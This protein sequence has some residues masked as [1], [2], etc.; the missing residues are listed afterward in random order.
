MRHYLFEVPIDDFS[1]AELDQHLLDWVKGNTQQFI[2]TP[3]SEF[4]LLSRK[5][6]EFRSI[7]Q[8]S[9]LALAD[10]VGLRYAIAAL[11]DHLLINRQTGVD[12]VEQLVRTAYKTNSHVVFFGGED[13]AAEKTRIRF[14]QKY[15]GVR[16]SVLNPGKIDLANLDRVIQQLRELE[17]TILIVALGQGKQERFIKH[18]LPH[19]PFVRI[20]VGV[21]GAFEMLG[22]LKPRAPMIMRRMGLE[23]VWR[24]L[25]EP[26]RIKRILNASI[27]FPL[28]VVWGTLKQ[29][30]FLKACGNV[31]PEIYRQLTGL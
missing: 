7:L 27:V 1:N 18:V 9:D 23:W 11:T 12:F 17:P 13:G 6:A 25:I 3:N 30:R 24:A 2:T 21:G 22:G 14:E 10:T 15:P 26:R 20:A 4:I 19:L 31:I 28:V 29:R 8:S 16:I 5:D